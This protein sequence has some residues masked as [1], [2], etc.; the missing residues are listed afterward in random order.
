MKPTTIRRAARRGLLPLGALVGFG[1]VAAACGS[2]STS[3]TSA[4]GGIYGPPSGGAAST[5]S[6]AASTVV[7]VHDSKLGKILSDGQGRTLYLFESD[8]GTMSTCN[9][10]C[11]SAWPALTT[12][13][14]AQAANGA[15]ASLIG[16]A[17][18]SDGSTQVTYA[19]HLLYYYA[20]DNQPGD[21]NGQGLNQFG[22][23]WDVLSP[24]GNKIEGGS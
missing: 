21:T 6:S 5:A 4:N 9:S 11:L 3:G 22:A 8:N 19:G 10:N 7:A 12:S 23:G 18:Q 16:T 24:Q 20:G 17:R 15:A 13:G 1:V 2:Y 14:N